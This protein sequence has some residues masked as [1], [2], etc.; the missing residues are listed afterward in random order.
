MISLK[1]L[2][3]GFMPRW[4]AGVAHQGLFPAA[5]D[6]AL[7]G[8]DSRMVATT[9]RSSALGASKTISAI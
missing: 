6:G 5:A 3:A 9:Y 8:L 7:E 1:L 4:A 2:G